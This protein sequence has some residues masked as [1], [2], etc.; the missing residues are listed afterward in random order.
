MLFCK[1]IEQYALVTGSSQTHL[2]TEDII[3]ERNTG[4]VTRFRDR[5]QRV[6]LIL[7]SDDARGKVSNVMGK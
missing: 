3:L 1:I 4:I 2:L 6:V 7:F 5:L